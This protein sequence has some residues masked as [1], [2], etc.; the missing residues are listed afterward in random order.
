MEESNMKSSNMILLIIIFVVWFVLIRG[1][2]WFGSKS[3][4]TEENESLIKEDTGKLE[5]ATNEVA[6]TATQV[7]GASQLNGSLKSYTM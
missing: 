2:G 4:E 6:D 3:N 7:A 5:L 1:V